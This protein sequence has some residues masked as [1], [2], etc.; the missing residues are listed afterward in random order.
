MLFPHLQEHVFENPEYRVYFRKSYPSK[1]K[2]LKDM[3]VWGSQGKADQVAK[4][5]FAEMLTKSGFL[6]I[7]F[8]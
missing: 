5:L 8:Y 1:Q 6:K 4:T 2:T 3:R 7:Q